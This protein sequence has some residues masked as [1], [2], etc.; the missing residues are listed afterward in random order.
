MG[1]GGE[2]GPFGDVR[3]LI[4]DLLGDTEGLFEGTGTRPC[5]VPR[6]ALRGGRG[7]HDGPRDRRVRSR[8]SGSSRS[9][10]E[11]EPVFLSDEE[12]TERVPRAVPGGV[13]AGG[14]PTSSSGL[15]ATARRDP[16]RHATCGELRSR[17]S[18]GS[19]WR[20]STTRRPASSWSATRA[21]TSPRRAGSRWRTSWTTPSPTRRSSIP[22]PTRIPRSGREDA[23]LAGARGRRGRR[24]GRRCS[25][26]RPRSV[27]RTSVELPRPRGDRR[28]ARRG[29]ASFPP[30][31][32]QELPFPYEEGL[33]FV[34]DVY[35]EGR[36]AGGERAPTTT[37]RRAPPGPVPRAVRRTEGA[38]DHDPERLRRPVAPDRR[39]RRAFGAANLSVALRGP[40][41]RHGQGARRIHRGA[42]ADWRGGELQLWTRRGAAAVGISLRTDERTPGALLC[43]AITEWYQASA[44]RT[45]SGPR[46]G[47]PTPS[48][49]TTTT[50]TR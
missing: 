3:R 39:G 22:L 40:G 6:D 9:S 33:A 31:L 23:N 25:V 19:R 41:W 1:R 48:C 15:L 28:G 45:T 49:G 4:E 27:S 26:T 35:A 36:V 42:V 47:R 16:A 17:R 38:A 10:E 20:A 8:A 12:M 30:Y 43:D 7:G 13:H 24:D 44:P 2:S 32:E 18:S 29:W 11:V 5:R 37:R 50:R 21:R 46:S 34:C 14:S